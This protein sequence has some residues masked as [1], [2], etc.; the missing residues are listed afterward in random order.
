MRFL[1]FALALG[2]CDPA[3]GSP[4]GG[5]TKSMGDGAIDPCA[6]VTCDRPP[7]SAC[8]SDQVRR[9]YSAHG[10][11]ANGLC[12]YGHTDTTC[13][14]G[15]DEGACMGPDPCDGVDCTS[16]PA[17][18]CADSHTLVSYPSSGTC[19]GGSCNYAASNVSCAQSCVS[20]ACQ[21]DPCAG[22]SCDQPPATYCAKPDTLRTF[23]A[24]GNC[25]AGDCTYSFSDT[26]CAGGCQNAACCV[27]ESDAE[28]CAAHSA[29]C[30]ALTATDRC[31][32]TRQLT[33]C[34]SCPAPLACAGNQCACQWTSENVSLDSGWLH[35]AKMVL[36][37]SGQPEI[38]FHR[39]ESTPDILQLI[40]ARKTGGAWV[41]SV[42]AYDLFDYYGGLARDA[43][44]NLHVSQTGKYFKFSNGAWS[45]G[46]PYL[47]TLERSL[48][49]TLAIAPDG[50]LEIAWIANDS[51]H[52]IH[53]ATRGAS[54]WA[55]EVVEAGGPSYAVQDDG[56]VLGTFPGAIPALAWTGDTNVRFALRG[57]DGH[58]NA[59]DVFALSWMAGSGYT[60]VTMEIDAAGGVRIDALDQ[61]AY[62]H[63]HLSLR[64]GATFDNYPLP[65]GW[66]VLA[67]GHPSAPTAVSLSSANPGPMT[68]SRL[69][70]GSFVSETVDPQVYDGHS[71]EAAIF[72]SANLWILVGGFGQLQ[73]YHRCAN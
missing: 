11:C 8:V 2:A 62:M 15:C 53:Y 25:S 18:F 13:Q 66:G 19:A 57:G 56:I 7:S 59:Q 21:G 6:G 69:N 24:S 14:N 28:L 17:G 23:A 16:P 29:V 3:P 63:Q 41:E 1:L 34:G 64:N 31:G 67:T 58:W 5:P 27:A 4:D 37:D 47:G 33:S 42:I 30:G 36:G 48:G 61:T 22:V 46:E 44:G 65:D 45:A 51:T 9:S 71:V 32:Q 35:N 38:V 72:D 54:G 55:G 68:I 26:H 20:G 40:H 73:L 70:A 50:T 52:S 39:T 10:S 60:N 43:A 12:S 49:S